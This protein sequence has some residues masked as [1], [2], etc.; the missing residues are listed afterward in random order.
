MTAAQSSERAASAVH[1][2]NVWA[3]ES[4]MNKGMM[5]EMRILNFG[6]EMVMLLESDE[7]WCCKGE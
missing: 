1:S 2:G 7:K 3:D 6:K 4:A 5:M